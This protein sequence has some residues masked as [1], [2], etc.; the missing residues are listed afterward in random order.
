MTPDKPASPPAAFTPRGRAFDPRLLEGPIPRSLFLLAVPIMGGNILQIAYQLVDAFWV[1]RLGAAAVAA[2][3][4]SMPMMFLMMSIGMGFTIA[5]STLIAQYVG[6]GNRGMVDHVAGQTML[7]VVA[8][9][10]ALGLFG[11]VVAPYLLQLMEVAPEVYRGA[12]G[13]LRVQFLSLPLAFAYFCFQSQM[14]GVGQVTVPLYLIAASVFINFILDPIFIFWLGWGVMGAALATM[15]SQFVS[16]VAAIA[17]LSSGRFGIQLKIRELRPDFAFILRAFN[18]GYPAAIEGSARGLGVTVMMF[19]ITSFGTV[20]TAAYGVGGNV[21][22]F[23]VI[24]AMGFSMATSTLVGQNIGAGNV[25]RAEAVAR[26]AA[27][28]TFGALSAFGLFALAFANHIAAFFVPHDKAVIHEASVFIRTVSWSFGFIGVQFALMGVLRASGNMFA[29][30]VISM[31]SQWMLTFPLAFVLSHR[32][33]MGAHGI[34]WA[35]P[36][37]NVI[38]AVISAVWF[39]RGDWKKRRIIETPREAEEEDVNEQVMV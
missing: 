6:A 26:L 17:L 29:A 11:F 2:V 7:T 5:G 15:V 32:A 9:S 34:W 14:R 22:Q 30:M 20:T 37:A 31:V 36:V 38:T 35:F 28:I 18:L 12:L 23:V 21:L 33:H 16:A 27:L 10:L 3:S 19:L 1:G 13:F 25:P 8:V 4:V 39:S 24:P